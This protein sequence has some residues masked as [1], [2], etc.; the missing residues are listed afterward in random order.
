MSMKRSYSWMVLLLLVSACQKDIDIFTPYE[1]T[2]A[3]FNALDGAIA[4]FFERA[5]PA[6]YKVE[7]EINDRAQIFTNQNTRIDVPA[8]AFV[9]E[10]GTPVNGSVE[11]AIL[12]SN[13]TGQVVGWQKPS[14]FRNE[15][16]RSI[17]VVEISAR[18]DDQALKL[19]PGKQLTIFFPTSESVGNINVYQANAD[20]NR[21]FE[22]E[23]VLGGANPVETQYE[24]SNAAELI[25]GIRF[26]TEQL[27]FFNLLVPYS[28]VTD[29]TEICALLPQGYDPSNTSLFYIG[30]ESPMVV[31]ELTWKQEGESYLF[32]FKNV[33]VGSSGQII[34]ITRWSDD[35]YAFSKRAVDRVEGVQQQF[36]LTP[37]GSDFASIL[38]ILNDL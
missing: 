30:A 2:D 27:G 9:T 21:Y 24:S 34:S 29:F 13:V 23:V 15:L 33:P 20:N 26:Q 12:E 4:A 16:L 32:C 5:K 25:Q 38:E 36:F 17:G 7:I 11:V 8:Q 10:A 31:A 14:V 18:K 35:Q 1:N 19:A 37:D 22:W 28:A 3:T 6:V